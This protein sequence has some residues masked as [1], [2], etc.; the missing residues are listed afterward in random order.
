MSLVL[1]D[2]DSAANSNTDSTMSGWAERAW[3]RS[4]I[5]TVR[6]HSQLT[7]NYS[8]STLLKSWSRRRHTAAGDVNMDVDGT[9]STSHTWWL[10]SAQRPLNSA[11]T[12]SRPSARHLRHWH[13]S[14]RCDLHVIPASMQE[15]DC[16]MHR[17]STTLTIQYPN[18]PFQTPDLCQRLFR[19]L[20]MPDSEHSNWHRLLTVFQSA[21]RQ[22]HS[23]QIDVTRLEMSTNDVLTFWHSPLQSV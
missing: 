18:D 19:K 2:Q 23:T 5:L 4:V 15:V 9:S 13:P 22:Y 1:I 6:L 17:L 3:W 21:Y 20:S 14:R 7:M 16:Y 8:S 11:N 10:W 12:C